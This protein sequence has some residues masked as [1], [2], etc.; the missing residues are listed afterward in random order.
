[1][2]LNSSQCSLIKCWKPL[3]PATPA[4]AT[5]SATAPSA[6]TV[7]TA[8]DASAALAELVTTVPGLGLRLQVSRGLLSVRPLPS[9]SCPG[10]PVT[11]VALFVYI[12]VFTGIDIALSILGN[13]TLSL[14]GVPGHGATTPVRLNA[15]GCSIITASVSAARR[16]SGGGI[17]GR[18]PAC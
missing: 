6:A 5:A 2:L 15:G 11:G 9:T 1:M 10:A 7:I 18:A 13:G 12:A 8:I 14:V 4:T 3:P 16:C 17:I